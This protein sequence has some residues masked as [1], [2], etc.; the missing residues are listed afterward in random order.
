MTFEEAV[1]RLED[2]VSRME[3]STLPLDSIIEKYEEGMKLV[4]YCSEKLTVAEKKIELLAKNRAGKL[5]RSKL[6]GKQVP[7]EDTPTASDVSLF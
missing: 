5:Q 1:E 3:S 2:I 6:D 7:V 4:D